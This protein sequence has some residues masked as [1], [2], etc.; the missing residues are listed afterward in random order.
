MGRRRGRGQVLSADQIA[1]KLAIPCYYIL[2]GKAY[3]AFPWTSTSGPSDFVQIIKL[4]NIPG[5]PG[6]VQ[7]ITVDWRQWK[8]VVAPVLENELWSNYLGS[9]GGGTNRRGFGIPGMGVDDGSGEGTGS[10]PGG[11]LG[12]GLMNGTPEALIQLVQGAIREQA[13]SM[14]YGPSAVSETIWQTVPI[15]PR[16]PTIDS[17][18]VGDGQ[19][20]VAFTL[21]NDGGS[22]VTDYEY[23]LDGGDTW[24]S[25]GSTTSPLTI[26][27]LENGTEYLIQ[28]RPVNEVGEGEASD[29]FTA[30]PSTTPEAPTV[31][32]VTEGDQELVVTV[33]PG[34][35]G[36]SPITDYEYTIDGGTNWISIGS[37]TSPLTIA[38]LVNGVSY[39]VQVRPVNDNGAGEPS[40][41]FVGTPDAGQPFAPTIDSIT[42]GDEELTVAF[43]AG[44]DNGF[45]ITDYE[46]TL[47]GVNYISAGTTTSPFTITGLTNGTSYPVQLRAVNVNGGGASSAIVNATPSTTASKPTIDSVTA[48]DGE[49]LVAITPGADGGDPVTDYEYTVDGGLNYISIGSTVSPLTIA[50]LVNGTPYTVQIRPVNGNGAGEPSDPFAGT[51]STVPGQPTID[52]ITAWDGELTVAFTAGDDGGSALTDIE[53]TL[54]GTN[55]ISAGTTTSPFTITGLTNGVTYPVQIRPVNANGTGTPSTVTNATPVDPGVTLEGPVVNQTGSNLFDV[56]DH[57]WLSLD[58]QLSAGERLVLST[59]FLADLVDAM[60]DNSSIIVGLKGGSW[61]NTSDDFFAG[62]LGG[63][64]LAITRTPT[65]VRI[66]IARNDGSYTFTPTYFTT[67]ANVTA[68]N[69]QAFFEVTADG[70]NIRSGFVGD[71]VNLTDDAST[72]AYADWNTTYKLETGDQGYGITSLDVMILGDAQPSNA[73]GMDS[74]D[75]DWTGL[76][77]VATPATVPDAPTID[78]VTS[79]DQELT[80]AFTA[81]SDGGSAITDYEYSLD[82]GAF[83][84]AG[85]TTSPFTIAGLNNGQTYSVVVRAI[86]AE[87]NGASSVADTGT[88]ST[89]PDAPTLVS[90]TPGDEQLSVAFTLNG[91]GGSTITDVE[92]Q[93]N[94]S[95]PWVSAGTTTSPFVITGLTNGVNYTITVRAVNANGPSAASNSLSSIPQVPATVPD[96]PTLNSVTSGDQQLTAAFTLGGTGGSPITD[97]EYRLNGGSWVSFGATTSPQVISGLTNGTPY[98]VEVRAVN[99]VGASAASNLIAGTPSTVPDAPTLNSLTSGSTELEAAFTLNGTGGSAIT[100]VE[101]R[102]NSGSWVSFGSTTSP[103]TITGLTNGVAYT[104]EVRAVNANGAS[105]ASNSLTETPAAS[106]EPTD[107]SVVAWVDA[108]DTSSYT[109][110]GSTLTAVTD[111]AGTYTLSVGGTPTRVVAG[112]NGLNTFDF[113]G[114]GEYIQSTAYRTQV[115]SGNHWAIGVFRPDSANSNKDSLWSYETNNSPKRDYAVSAGSTGSWPGELDLDGLSSNRISST[116]GNLQ[117]WNLQSLSL[118][119]WAIVVT[120]FNKTGNQIGCRKNGNNCFTPVND[121]DNNVQASQ[122]LRLMRNR[123]SEELNGQL[124][125]FFAVAGLPGTGGTD[126]S[127]VEKAEGYLAWKWGLEGQLP[128][129]HPY[130]N[131]PP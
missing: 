64:S 21:G 92:Y 97:V 83:V 2:L 42:T 23:T 124:A 8:S 13:V 59:A 93:I 70:N 6:W 58:E 87:G 110:S 86:N 26:T 30:T 74:A 41:P 73:A 103:Q 19:L 128:A 65:D 117:V 37:T 1:E 107:V 102:L 88:P 121:Y 114:N 39:T 122:E 63:I 66:Q 60:P 14:G 80:V 40:A 131:S 32:S 53:Y 48:G 62:F 46:Y 120:Y 54:D 43:T 112:R 45:P 101:Y 22:P 34:D 106:W 98:N 104:V 69:V 35:D 108:S 55:Y 28:I 90:L 79:G 127:D 52:S 33:T 29:P 47:D 7:P 67:V 12:V 25:T 49:L 129:G 17:V 76:S 85:T 72:T 36:G 111:K 75:V 123:S 118:G 77:E 3:P 57:G 5:V 99:A 61:T 105:A 68:N 9:T 16:S 11:T 94:V 115:S 100:D 38:P 126:L 119:S 15:T 109:L 130:K 4:G 50:P 18:T 113:D 10:S 44:G 20:L 95:G 82:G 84:S 78:S 96:A 31:G 27:G 71:D 91:D 24:T 125:E 116:I 81:G 56:G 89:I 51:P